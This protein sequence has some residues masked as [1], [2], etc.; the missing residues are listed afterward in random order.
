MILSVGAVA[1]LKLS[2][3]AAL[4]VFAVSGL[5]M[6]LPSSPGAIGVYEAVIVTTLKH[7]EVGSDEAL[8]LALFSH[9]AQFL[10]VTA[11]GGIIFAAFPA[12]R[13]KVS[14]L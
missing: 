5:G 13:A 14:E 1:Q 11:A 6:L 8:A 10:P 9:M 12:K 4:S 3:S 7:Y 2:W